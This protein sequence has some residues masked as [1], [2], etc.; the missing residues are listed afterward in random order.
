MDS[1]I[2][3]ILNH[4]GNTHT[5]VE[6]KQGFLGNYYSP[7]ID[8]IYVVEDFEKIKMP[9][10][11][12]KINPKAAKLIMVCHECIHSIQSKKLHILNT[13]F[14]NISLILSVVYLFIALVG[15]GQL[16][17]K[18][19]ALATITTSIVIRLILELGATNGSTELA[20]EL[21]NKGFLDC[22]SAEDIQESV[23]YIRK[24]RVVALTQ[25]VVDKIVFLILV[26]IF[27]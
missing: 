1:L 9:N 8:T 18:M 3:E 4:I 17:L 14:A 16:W 12:K 23:E 20:K 13:I 7:L 22:V 10:D 26:L 25:M 24:H 27:K 21:V 2:K 11:A 6:R 15:T 19:G 5:K